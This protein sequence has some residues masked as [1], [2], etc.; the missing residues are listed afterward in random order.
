[1]NSEQYR[2]IGSPPLE[3]LPPS[4]R[5]RSATGTSME[6]QGITTCHIQIGQRIYIQQFIVCNKMMPHVI[7]GRDFLSTYKLNIWGAARTM[8]VLDGRKPMVKMVQGVCQYPAYVAKRVVVPPRTVATIPVV[9]NVPPFGEKILFEFTPL[10]EN[11]D[12][13][14]SYTQWTM[15]HG[16]VDTRW[17]SK[18][19]QTSHG[20][21]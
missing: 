15:P 7:V 18:F 9:T 17:Q 8:E 12:Q 10:G 3:P 19:L 14:H 21:P 4:A 13:M 20:N 16:G 5:L 2:M 11:M 6:A 1:M